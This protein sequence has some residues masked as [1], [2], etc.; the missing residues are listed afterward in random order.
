MA[1]AGTTGLG[2]GDVLGCGAL[3]AGSDAV[4]GLE[5]ETTDGSGTAPPEAPSEAP[6]PAGL[7]P[8]A[9]TSSAAEAAVRMRRRVTGAG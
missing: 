4:D 3:E 1:S 2:S 7:G 5:L 8:Q 6:E 9:A